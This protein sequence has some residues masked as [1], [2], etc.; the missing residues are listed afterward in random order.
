MHRKKHGKQRSKISRGATQ[1]R[2]QSERKRKAKRKEKRKHSAKRDTKWNVAKRSVAK[3]NARC[4]ECNAKRN[5]PESSVAMYNVEQREG[6]ERKAKQ[7][8][9]ET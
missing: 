3:R 4:N 8:A 7:R 6:S 1:N 2:T 5:N 9:S